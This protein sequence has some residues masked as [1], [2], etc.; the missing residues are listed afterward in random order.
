MGVSK[1]FGDRTLGGTRIKLD[2]HYYA[3]CVVGV[4]IVV[5][6]VETILVQL[7]KKGVFKARINRE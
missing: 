1:K 5:M 4:I 3:V 2:K 6:I 7:A